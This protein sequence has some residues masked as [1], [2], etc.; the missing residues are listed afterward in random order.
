MKP[1]TNIARWKADPVALITEASVN[2]ETG[3][4]WLA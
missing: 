3:K 1:H 4:L 2:P